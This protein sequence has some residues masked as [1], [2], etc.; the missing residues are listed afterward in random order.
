[1]CKKI[2]ET[3]LQ[4]PILFFT[5]IASDA[6]K[7]KAFAAGANAFLAKPD[8]IDVLVDFPH[9]IECLSEENRNKYDGNYDEFPNIFARAA[10]VHSKLA[11]MIET[12][13]NVRV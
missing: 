2:R 5:A 6:N 1:M 10:G 4:T 7:R 12:M 9:G 8:G 13:R 3:D 11:E